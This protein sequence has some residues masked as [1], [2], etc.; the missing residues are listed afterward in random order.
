MTTPEYDITKAPE[1]VRMLAV[2]DALDRMVADL[3]VQDGIFTASTGLQLKLK[4]VSRMIILDATRKLAIPQ[5]PRQFIESKGREEENP[6]DP[7]YQT[8]YNSYMYDIGMIGYAT[9]FILGTV[10]VS[11]PDDLEPSE[12]T[13]WS[14]N[15]QAVHEDLNIPEKGP[16]RYFAWLKYYALNEQDQNALLQACI[17]YSGGTLEADVKEAQASFRDI[18]AGDTAAGVPA[19]TAVERRDNDGDSV[20]NGAGVRGEGSGA[21]LRPELDRLDEQGRLV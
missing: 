12:G 9:Y 6:A 16:R 5:P 15:I 7:A 13:T 3:P 1:A 18:Q 10:P 8:A 4:K 11:M 2:S 21:L 17:R 19:Q 20:R 14:D